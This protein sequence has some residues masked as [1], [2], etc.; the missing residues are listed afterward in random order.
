MG[1]LIPDGYW[2]PERVAGLLLLAGML[3]PILMLGLFALRGE[4]SDVFSQIGG[5]T[6]NA[7]VHKV[8][9]SGWIAASLLSLAGYVLL[10]VFLG[11]EG[12]VLLSPVA[13]TGMVLTTILLV[14]EATIHLAFGAWAMDEVLRTGTQ[15]VLYPVF[16]QWASVILQRVYLPLGYISLVLFG[17]SVLQ[18]VLLPAWSGWMTIGWGAGMFG[19][20][21][22][23]KTTLPASLY[24]PGAVFG[25]LLL[26]KG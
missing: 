10:A 8:S 24:L 12:E 18:T 14:V 21:V 4:L 13:R 23:S 26:V 22:L 19:L 16:F 17:W 5:L 1:N 11:Q 25:V 7:F 15:P 20:L 3:V 6:R 9:L 2:K